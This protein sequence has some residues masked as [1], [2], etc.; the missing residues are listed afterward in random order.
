M[1][2]KII[3]IMESCPVGLIIQSTTGQISHVDL[4][5]NCVVVAMKN[6][7]NTSALKVGMWINIHRVAG[8]VIKIEIE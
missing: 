3:E 5:S 7:L 6:K 2:A 1:E 8:V 4:D